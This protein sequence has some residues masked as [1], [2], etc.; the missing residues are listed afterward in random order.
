M[1]LFV[2]VIMFVL[3]VGMDDS[4]YDGVGLKLVLMLVLV[5][6]LVLELVWGVNSGKGRC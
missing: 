3:C 5:L 1:L 4:A 6:V 2:F